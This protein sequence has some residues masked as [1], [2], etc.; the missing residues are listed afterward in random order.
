[1]SKK[2]IKKV[3]KK[4]LFWFCVIL[5]FVIVNPVSSQAAVQK[6]YTGWK[7]IDDVKYYYTNGVM[8]TGWK[9]IGKYDYYF[10]QEGRMQVNRIVGTKVAGYYYVDKWGRKMTDPEMQ[11]AV[12]FVKKNTKTTQSR[13][14]RLETCYKA[15]CKYP[16]RG[17]THSDYG[18][19]ELKKNANI[20]FEKGYGDCIGYASA[21]A[22]IARALG[23]DS[24]VARGAVTYR[25]YGDL[26]PHAWCEFKV[27]SVWYIADC[28]EQRVDPNVS[29]YRLKMSQYPYRIRKDYVMTL[30]VNNAKFIFK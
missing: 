11:K 15:L 17:Q 9:T 3:T 25:T 18:N 24:R 12:A 20:M 14:E 28:S 5:M 4:T 19:E 13:K 29:L 23:Y 27:G 8:V 2:A 1:M 16:Y 26:K 6:N 10:N 21:F 30:Y 22:Y 7:T